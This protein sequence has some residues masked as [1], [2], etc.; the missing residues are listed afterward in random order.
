[1]AWF[2]RDPEATAIQCKVVFPVYKKAYD[3]DAIAKR[4][5]VAPRPVGMIAAA[6]EHYKTARVLKIDPLHFGDIEGV[7]YNEIGKLWSGEAKADE[8][9]KTIS[10]KGTE[11]LMGGG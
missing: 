4:W 2:S 6:K 9:A 1:M 11:I 10:E 7:Y 8:V 3:D 5:L